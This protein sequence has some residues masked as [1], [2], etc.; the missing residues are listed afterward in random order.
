MK[1]HFNFFLILYLILSILEDVLQTDVSSAA[2]RCGQAAQ[3][4]QLGA[5][6]PFS[7]FIRK[8]P[9]MLHYYMI[10]LWCRFPAT[11]DTHSKESAQRHWLRGLPLYTVKSFSSCKRTALSEALY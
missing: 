5:G 10:P 7:H 1:I 9:F 11:Q 3:I 8:E 2:H 6:S 4:I